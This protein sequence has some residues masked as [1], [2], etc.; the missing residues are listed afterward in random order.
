MLRPTCYLLV[1]P[2]SALPSPLPIYPSIYPSFALMGCYLALWNIPSPFN[3]LGSWTPH[4]AVGG[5]LMPFA[6]LPYLSYPPLSP[7]TQVHTNLNKINTISFI[8]LNL[9]F[10]YV[11]SRFRLLSSSRARDVVTVRRIPLFGY[12]GSHSMRYDVPSY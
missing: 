3:T 9:H 12:R 8:H 2:R 4:P 5:P 1:V 10:A 6:P 11:L 7:L